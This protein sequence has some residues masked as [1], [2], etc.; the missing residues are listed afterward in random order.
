M[1]ANTFTLGTVHGVKF[2]LQRL[3]GNLPRSQLTGK[4]KV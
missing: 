3:G 2:S 4:T 1:Y